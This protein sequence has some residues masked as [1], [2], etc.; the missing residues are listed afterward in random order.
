MTTSTFDQ[1]EPGDDGIPER[2]ESRRAWATGAGVML[3]YN[4]TL[5]ASSSIV[6]AGP[7]LSPINICQGQNWKYMNSL[8]AYA[9]KTASR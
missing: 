1:R 4:D 6:P 8:P 3:E 7:T 2:V 5:T 9:P